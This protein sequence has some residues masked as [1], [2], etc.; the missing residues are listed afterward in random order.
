MNAFRT[1]HKNDNFTKNICAQITIFFNENLFRIQSLFSPTIPTSPRPRTKFIPHRSPARLHRAKPITL[2]LWY[3]NTCNTIAN[4]GRSKPLPYRYSAGFIGRREVCNFRR[5]K[6][7]PYR[8][9]A[10]FIGKRE[11]CNFGRSKP[12]PFRYSA[13]FIGRR[14]ICNF[15]RS[16]P[17]PF[18]YSAGFI[19]RREVCNFGRSL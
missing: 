9:F 6:P 4:F 1:I 18:R 12:L 14:E 8:Y 7:L 19:G 15:G 10:G 5:S 17:L 2:I 13:G 3:S 16:K 11:V